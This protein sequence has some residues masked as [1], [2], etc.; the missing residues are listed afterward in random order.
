MLSDLPIGLLPAAFAAAIAARREERGT[1]LRRGADAI[2]AMT[3]AAGAGAAATGVWDWLTIP[4]THPA[5]WPATLHGAL[6]I[7]NVAALGAAAALPRRRVGLYAAVGGGILVSGW[8]GGDLV[9]A[10]G[11]RV[12]PAEEYEQLVERIEPAEDEALAEARDVVAQFEREK[13]FLPA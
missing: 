6:N 13:T 10:H 12:R 4:R 5:W 8:L 2:A 7:A 11:W 1:P 9:F 3:F